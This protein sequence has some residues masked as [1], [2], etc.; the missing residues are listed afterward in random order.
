MHGTKVVMQNWKQLLEK[1][2]NGNRNDLFSRS[3]MYVNPQLES[4]DSFSVP[5]SA[6]LPCSLTRTF[7]SVR[8]T[9][10]YWYYLPAENES[11]QTF[12]NLSFIIGVCG[13]ETSKK[14]K[15]TSGA[16]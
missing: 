13:F 11:F 8:R 2:Q 7:T 12:V 10:S 4:G 9:V 14:K 3:A 5:G 6:L 16:G 1:L 15:S